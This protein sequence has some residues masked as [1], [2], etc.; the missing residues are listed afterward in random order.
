MGR[1]RQAGQ[2]AGRCTIIDLMVRRR[3]QMQVSGLNTLRAYWEALRQDGDVPRRLQV[4]PRGIENALDIAFLA[5]RV[6]PRVARFRLAGRQLNALMGMEVRGMPLTALIEPTAR[7]DFADALERVFDGPA[8]VEM[9]LRGASG[10]TQPRLEARMLLLPLRAED[11]SI[12]RA[13]GGLAVEGRV[14]TPPRRLDLT[15]MEITALAGVP[16]PERAP[17]GRD[18]TRPPAQ[19][20]AESPAGF[21]HAPRGRPQLRVIRNDD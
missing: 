8:V 14:G 17:Q 3:G 16:M 6:A 18:R 21:A 20:L 5:E 2:D 11:G 1:G 4:D 13:L 10:L 15:G 12:S 7:D 9:A 19:G